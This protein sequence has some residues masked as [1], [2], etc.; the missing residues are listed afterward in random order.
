MKASVKLMSAV[1]LVLV[2][3]AVGAAPVAADAPKADASADALVISVEVDGAG[4]WVAFIGDDEKGISAEDFGSLM[5]LMGL[6]MPVPVLDASMVQAVKDSGVESLALVKA[7][8]ETT[9]LL[10]GEPVSAI[11]ITEAAVQEMANEFLPELGGLLSWLNTTEIA[12]VAYFPTD[13]EYA[14]VSLDSR[15]P[16]T[17]GDDSPAN[18]LDVAATIAPDGKLIS[19][20]GVNAVEL[21]IPATQI[22]LSW[23][24]PIAF[25]N[26]SVAVD[27]AGAR[28]STDGE[29]WLSVAWNVDALVEAAP[30]IS[31]AAGFPLAA[32]DEEAMALAVDWLKDTRVTVGAFVAETTQEEAPVVKVG[33]P[34]Q[35]AVRGTDLLV[36][37]IDTGFRLDD[38]MLAYAQSIGSVSVVWDGEGR[39]LRTALGGTLMPALVVDDDF[40][41]AVGDATMGSAFLPW[42]MLNTLLSQTTVAADFVYADNEVTPAETLDYQVTYQEPAAPLTLDLVVS[43]Q[44]GRV[45]AWGESLPLDMPGM[46]IT[47]SVL[48][49]AK[50][51][52]PDLRTLS[53]DLGP[54]GLS[55]GVNGSHV[56]LVWDSA[57]RDAVLS[58]LLDVGGR[59]FGLPAVATSGLVET[60]LQYLL[61]AANQVELGIRVEL[62]D[63]AIPEGSIESLAHQVAL[64]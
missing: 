50:D 58:M 63:E 16:A 33:R 52:G 10:N 9:I 59:E 60:G 22:D 61:G 39:Q 53:L 13:G 38:Q 49:Y 5:A 30:D 27:S 56:N 11:H 64:Y 2:A 46:G 3:L 35:I 48:F 19:V 47:E 12:L 40:V 20:G 42:D 31:K 55:F 43:R 17:T 6:D 37:G 57:S 28:L 8:E 34:V 24:Q 23:L 36:E 26:L 51:A 18:V 21:G 7:G 45:A 44:D 25:E 14:E 54:T 1:V 41:S 4:G 29:E 62:T 15:L 32:E